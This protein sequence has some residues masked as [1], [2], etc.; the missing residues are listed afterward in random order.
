MSYT[1]KKERPSA[2]ISASLTPKDRF[3]WKVPNSMR[4]VEPNVNLVLDLDAACVP[5]ST[6]AAK[7]NTSASTTTNNAGSAD[8]QIQKGDPK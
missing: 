5:N 1:G 6:F 8:S 3:A 4:E 7:S 2:L